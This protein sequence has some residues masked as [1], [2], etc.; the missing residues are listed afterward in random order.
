MEH[1]FVKYS[2]VALAIV[3]LALAPAL[4]AADSLAPLLAKAKKA[5]LER[6]LGYSGAMP[7]IRELEPWAGKKL[8]GRESADVARQLAA[9]YEKAGLHDRALAELERLHGD[10]ELPSA[11]RC[12][13]FLEAAGL[14]SADLRRS[15][16]VALLD[17]A[18]KMGRLTPKDISRLLLARGRILLTPAHFE[19]VPSLGD[20]DEAAKT[21]GKA[22]QTAG[23]TAEERFQAQNS[24]VDA[25][26]DA[27]HPEKSIALADNCLKTPGL[28]SKYRY[29]FLLGNGDSYRAMKKYKEALSSYERA[30]DVARESPSGKKAEA[31]ERIGGVSRILRDWSRA[32]QAYSDLVPLTSKSDDPVNYKFFVHMVDVL[33][34]VTRKELKTATAEEVFGEEDEDLLD[35]G[36]DE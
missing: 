28:D 36:L 26:R 19:E 2:P 7:I 11:E 32:Q 21:I 24:L 22:L 3:L 16:A 18:L 27:G 34:T 15:R 35:L 20:L 23:L 31:L 10:K 8:P 30:Y 14:L 1:S 17:E 4:L 29:D 9:L 25:Y 6:G 13:A 12:E 5:S 33:T